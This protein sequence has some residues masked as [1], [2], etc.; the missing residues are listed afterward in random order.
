METSVEINVT[1]IRRCFEGDSPAL[2]FEVGNQKQGYYFCGARRIHATKVL[3]FDHAFGCPLQTYEHNQA[4]EIAGKFVYVNLIR[5]HS[6]SSANL[7][8][9]QL[10]EELMSRGEYY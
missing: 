5:K 7:T 9:Q 8:K 6:K 3:N 10:V 4:I 2:E 1:D